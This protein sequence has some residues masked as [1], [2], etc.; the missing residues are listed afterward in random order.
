MFLW[1]LRDGDGDLDC[2]PRIGDADRP[3]REIPN[4]LLSAEYKAPNLYS[5][6]RRSLSVLVSSTSSPA[7]RP[8]E[9]ESLEIILGTF[10]INLDIT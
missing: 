9:S 3:I 4:V 1:P 6:S 5:T 8:S 7:A 2:L 10:I